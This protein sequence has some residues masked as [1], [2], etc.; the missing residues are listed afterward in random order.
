MAN[1][2]GNTVNKRR[3]V[4]FT[5][6]AS[7]HL[8]S[9]PIAKT[10]NFHSQS[11]TE[12][13]NP[14]VKTSIQYSSKPVN[15]HLPTDYESIGKA[16]MYGPPERIAKAVVKCKLLTKHVLQNVLRLLLSEVCGLCSRSNPSLLRKC[17]KN[18]LIKLDFQLLC[19]EWK[20]RAPIF[21]SFLMTCCSIQLSQNESWFP[22][23]A[24]AGSVSL[25]QRNSQ[26]NA[27]ASVLGIL[28][29]TR[30]IEV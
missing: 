2:P 30:S 7:L 15:K 1:C 25:K 23:M 3:F 24:V 18:D 14:A 12:P 4:Y 17:D 26:M 19:E 8:T 16:L 21:Y 28:I 27:L 13:C 22:S 11:G 10:G 9:T 29:K 6:A 5:S 20:D